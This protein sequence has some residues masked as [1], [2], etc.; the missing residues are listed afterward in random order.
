M[1]FPTVEAI[2]GE[3]GPNLI[4]YDTI[5][6]ITS[7]CEHPEEAWKFIERNLMT[8]INGD[9]KYFP[10]GKD[11]LETKL[12]EE[13]AANYHMTKEEEESWREVFGYRRS[14]DVITQEQA[15]KVRSGLENSFWFVR[16]TDDVLYII[17]EETRPYFAG[18]KSLDETVRILQSRMQVYLDEIYK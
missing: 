18:Q 16:D 11:A 14:V 9:V 4:Y 7:T 17:L 10:T 6:G 8:A 5:L 2:P 12:Q 3:P 13:T 1:G 15:D